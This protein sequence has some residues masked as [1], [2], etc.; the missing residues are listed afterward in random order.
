MCD[1]AGFGH[2]ALQE[3]DVR[4]AIGAILANKYKGGPASSD[5]ESL[6]MKRVLDFWGSWIREATTSSSI[7]TAS[8][9]YYNK[10]AMSVIAGAAARQDKHVLGLIPVLHQAAASQHASGERVAESIGVVVKQNDL[11]TPDNHAVVKRFYKQWVY[12]H[13]VRPLLQN[14]QPG[15]EDAHTATRYRVAVLSVVS[16]CPFTVY[17]DDLE[18]LM[19]LLVTALKNRT[20]LSEDVAWSQVVSALEILAEIL[21]NEPNALKGYLRE[22]IGAATEVYQECVQKKTAAVAA[23]PATRTLCRKLALQI[24][25]A[26]PARFEERHVLAYAPPTQR[27]LAVACGDP[28]RKVREIARRARSAWAKVV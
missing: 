16:N 6:V 18:P 28:V 13:L 22:I 24:L 19:R 17:Q 10:I 11:L 15:A 26:I 4:A 23:Q 25:G 5:P 14:A 2:S 7:D 27:L 20:G 8:F 3:S 21:A 12:G 9:A 1:T